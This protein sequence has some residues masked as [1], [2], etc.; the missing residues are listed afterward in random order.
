[1]PVTAKVSAS[2]Y[3]QLIDG[4]IPFYK[5]N[6]SRVNGNLEYL[7]DD[8]KVGIRF[9]HVLNDDVNKDDRV[10][11]SYVHPYNLQD[12]E[13]S[14]REAEEKCSEEDSIY[15]SKTEIARSLED[16]PVHQVTIASNNAYLSQKPVVFLTCRV[17]SGET[18]AQ[19]MLQ[20]FIDKLLDF[21]DEHS[22]SLL[23][24]YVFKI[25]PC[26]NPDGVARGQWRRD[27]SGNDLNR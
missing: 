19:F 17:H 27:T 5:L 7:D 12:I 20:G 1:M 18:P 21:E 8:K 9:D 25:I 24:N 3:Q 23:D 14:I 13:Y 10:I 2:E 4:E 15:F 16:R 22:K 6:W 11:F 26:L